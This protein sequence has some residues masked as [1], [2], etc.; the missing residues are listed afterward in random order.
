MLLVTLVLFSLFVVFQVLYIFV[1]I[2]SVRMENKVKFAEKEKPISIIVPAFNEGKIIENC[3]NGIKNL[4][5]D[6]FE[7][8]FVNDGSK[9]DTFQKLNSLL[10]LKLESSSAVGK[11]KHKIIQGVY[12]SSHFPNIR[13]INKSNGGKADALNAGI[14]YAMSDIV[15]TLDA[16][17]VLDSNALKA[18]NT[19][20]MDESVIAAGGVVQIG[21]GYRGSYH[22]PEPSFV[23]KGIIRYQIIQYMTAF[24]LHKWTQSKFQSMTVIA[25]AF[26]AFR[27]KALFEAEGYRNTV[28]EDMDIT[29]RMQ[30]LIKMKYKKS[31]MVFVPQAICYTECP[32]TF[33]DLLS[34]RIR[35]QKAFIDCIW[36]YRTSFFRKMGVRAS[37][38]LILDSLLLGTLNAF[39]MV[40]IPL[41]I[42]LN[43]ETLLIAAMLLT[44][45]F[46]LAC[47][48]SIA[49]LLIGGRFDIRY[50]SKDYG[51]LAVF[52]PLEIVTYRLLGL[53]FVISGTILYFKNRKGWN[54]SRRVGVSYQTFD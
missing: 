47:Y 48:Q 51:R 18:I 35:W 41:T 3:L 40:F 23:T 20:F 38:Y 2:F 44:F 17:S 19:S 49:A 39:I 12:R 10:D 53:L 50:K 25:G 54:V 45:T 24:Y 27:K 52:I 46:I 28:G 4:K 36:T 29:L 14:E 30:R 11:L 43:P 13:V 22:K 33:K 1:P 8:I 42:L 37:L 9:D 7:A 16:D 34:Q 31:R 32:S 6:H 15:I 26:G 21:Q 5:Y